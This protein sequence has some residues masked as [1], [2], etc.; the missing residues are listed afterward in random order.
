MK[1]CTIVPNYLPNLSYFCLLLQYDSWQID[2]DFPFQ[3]QSYRNRCEILLSNKVEK[4]VVPIRKLKGTDLMK[5]VIIDYKEDWRKKHWRGIQSAYGKTPFFEYYAPFFEK[6]F[7][8]EHLRLIDLNS[9]L[10]NVVLKCLNLKPRFTA[11]EG[12]ESLSR[13]VVGKKFVLEFNGPSYEQPF[14]AVFHPNLS[15][16]D[17][18]FNIGP[19]SLSFLKG[20]QISTF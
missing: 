2:E 8:K 6:T 3:K 14:G 17:L 1:S 11:D 13:L 4:L 12:T 16:I 20:Y 7:Q 9:E 10:L 18:L 19:E 15:I 5:D